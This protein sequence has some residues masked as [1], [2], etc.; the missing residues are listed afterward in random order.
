MYCQFVVH[1]LVAV[2]VVFSKLSLVV[3][4]L[5]CYHCILMYYAEVCLDDL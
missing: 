5:L 1:V 2:P 4:E 3:I